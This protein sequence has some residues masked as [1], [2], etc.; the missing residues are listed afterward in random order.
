[1][2]KADL[3]RLKGKK[4]TGGGFGSAQGG[5]GAALSKRE[6]ALEQ[7]RELLKKLQKGKP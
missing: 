1:M 3:E 6:Q 4:I 7:K 2:K 5:Q